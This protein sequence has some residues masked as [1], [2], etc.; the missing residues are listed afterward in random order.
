MTTASRPTPAGRFARA[1]RMS[2]AGLL[3]IAVV[4][5][6]VA[7]VAWTDE[8]NTL[9]YELAK[10]AMQV[11]AVAVLGGLATIATAIFQESFKRETARHDALVEQRR[12]QDDLLRDRSTRRSPPT[13][14]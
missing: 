1:A 5:A 10:I 8:P 3:V 7:A 4:A 11:V 12:S 6:A 2:V 13:T 9:E 14:A